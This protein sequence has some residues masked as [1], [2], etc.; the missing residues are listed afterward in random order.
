M[1]KDEEKRK[2]HNKD[3]LDWYHKNK[4]RISIRRKELLKNPSNKLKKAKSYRKSYL[5]N[6]EKIEKYKREWN[7]KN[8]LRLNCQAKINYWK[9]KE[10]KNDAFLKIYARK[11]ARRIQIPPGQLCQDCNIRLAIGKHHEDYFKPLE[12]KFL[13]LDCHNKLRRK[14]D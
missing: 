13:C 14:Y 7:K 9:N 12:V 6:K 3:N 4:S 11:I 10:S 1:D 8:R 2:Q 5:K